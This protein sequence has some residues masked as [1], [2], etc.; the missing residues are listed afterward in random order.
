MP[1]PASAGKTVPVVTATQ[2]TYTTTGDGINTVID[3]HF[4]AAGTVEGIRTSAIRE[5][6]FR[7]YQGFPNEDIWST[8]IDYTPSTSTRTTSSWSASHS[9]QS[10]A[11]PIAVR[12]IVFLSR[13]TVVSDPLT[14]T[15][16]PG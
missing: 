12:M 10:L 2:C 4:S 3:L 16:P 13:S 8:G 6:G 15:G 5:V 1:Q 7:S 9:V 14:C 11:T